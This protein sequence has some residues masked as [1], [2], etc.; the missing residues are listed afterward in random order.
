MSSSKKIPVDLSIMD[1]KKMFDAEELPIVL[2]T[3]YESGVKDDMLSLI[4]QAKRNVTFAVKT[5]T[6]MTEERTIRNKTMQGMC[7]AHLCQVTWSTV[8]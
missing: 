2:N 1:F 6:G 4:N 3:L 7:L 5:P 8:I